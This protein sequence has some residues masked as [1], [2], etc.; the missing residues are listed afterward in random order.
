[1]HVGL[2]TRSGGFR[3]LSRQMPERKAEIR[4]TTNETKARPFAYLLS[5]S[6]TYETEMGSLRIVSSHILFEVNLQFTWRNDN[7]QP[8]QNCGETSAWANR[9]GCCGKRQSRGGGKSWCGV[10]RSQVA[11]RS[12]RGVILNLRKPTTVLKKRMSE[13]CRYMKTNTRL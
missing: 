9:C 11:L 1:M 4:V 10:C 13:R 12:G 3:Q 7:V 8:S 5:V 2:S 6:V